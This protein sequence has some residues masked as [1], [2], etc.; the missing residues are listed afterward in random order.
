VRDTR[1]LLGLCSVSY[2]GCLSNALEQSHPETSCH[3]TPLIPL[4][5][6]APHLLRTPTDTYRRLLPPT[7]CRALTHHQQS[8]ERTQYRTRR[9]T[10]SRD[11][12]QERNGSA[13]SSQWMLTHPDHTYLSQP[14]PSSHTSTGTQA[15]TRE[16]SLTQKV[17]TLE[18]TSSAASYPR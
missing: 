6:L 5:T 11:E 7:T 17:L 8:R 13:I 15:C 14:K 9:Y 2:A 10:P 18:S 4:R 1:R 3:V 16:D 12:D